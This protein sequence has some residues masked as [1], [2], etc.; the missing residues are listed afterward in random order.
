M[1]VVK[2]VFVLV[3]GPFIGAVLGGIVAAFLLPPDPTGSGA[4]GGGFLIIYCVGVGFVF[5]AVISVVAAIK[6]ARSAKA[7]HS[8]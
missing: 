5:S 4:P 6:I 8:T 2:I 1:R 7:K 3:A